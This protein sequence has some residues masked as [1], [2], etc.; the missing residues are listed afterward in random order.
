MK[1]CISWPII[2][3]N[4]IFYCNGCYFKYIEKKVI[5]VYRLNNNIKKMG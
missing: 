4:D 5:L 3:R 1:Y 2:L